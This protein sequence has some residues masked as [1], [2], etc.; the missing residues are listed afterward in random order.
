MVT[1]CMRIL[2]H[3]GWG[4]QPMPALAMLPCYWGCMKVDSMH[5]PA[6]DHHQRNLCRHHRQ[7]LLRMPC[8]H[9]STGGEASLYLVRCYC[10]LHCSLTRTS[11]CLCTEVATGGICMSQVHAYGSLTHCLHTLQPP[12]MQ[13]DQ[14]CDH[15]STYTDAHHLPAPLTYEH[16]EAY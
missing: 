16:P 4:G 14:R 13:R 6:T 9:N 10:R 3:P 2:V 11:T 8:C 5:C 15:R 7:G 1:I 12:E